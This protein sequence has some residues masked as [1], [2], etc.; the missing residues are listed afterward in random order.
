MLRNRETNR[1]RLTEIKLQALLH[2]KYQQLQ[3]NIFIH[4]YLGMY[5]FINIATIINCS[6]RAHPHLSTVPILYSVQWWHLNLYPLQDRLCHTTCNSI[7]L[8]GNRHAY[9]VEKNKW[10]V[11]LTL[12]MLHVDIMYLACR[13]QK[14]ATI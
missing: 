13:R 8:T 10:H 1:E 11:K 2:Q 6:N 9:V 12:Y 4:L 14:Y 7:V 3:G 5:I